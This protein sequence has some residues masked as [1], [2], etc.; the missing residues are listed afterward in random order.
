MR[1]HGRASPHLSNPYTRP[2]PNPN[3]LLA[4]S[5]R[6]K[7][8]LEGA[9]IKSFPGDPLFAGHDLLFAGPCRGPLRIPM[10][11]FMALDFDVK[12]AKVLAADTSFK[13]RPRECFK[14][15]GIY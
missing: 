12:E 4:F 1:N 8:L 13:W 15:A 9:D 3:A 10:A 2:I 6:I 11:K 5:S 7:F 14:L